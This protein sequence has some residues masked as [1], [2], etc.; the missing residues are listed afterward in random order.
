M[1]KGL[2]HIYTGDGKGKTTAAVG[3]AVRAAS[4]GLKTL[5]AQFFKEKTAGET[6]MLERLGIETRVFDKVKSPFFHPSADK[7]ELRKEIR[8][9]LSYLS[10]IFD[11]RRF[12][13]VI[14]DEFICLVSENLLSEDEA[15]RFIAGKPE[16][17]EL[18]LTGR[19]AGERLI[20]NADY[21]TNMQKVKHPYRNQVASRKGIEF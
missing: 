19:G 2:I 16:G 15:L 6:A 12:D 9:A 7:E 13:L 4:R 8:S 14:L 3:L 5:Y 10:G 20:N 18:V 17:L 1:N 11:E 21:V